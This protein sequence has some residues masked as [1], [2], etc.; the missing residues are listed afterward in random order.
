[1]IL[2]YIVSKDKIKIEN[3]KCIDSL[4]SDNDIPKIIIGREFSKELNVKTSV[5]DKKIDKNS[6]WTYSQKEKKSEYLEDIEK[7]KI[8]C[9]DNFLKKI[10][11]FYI[12]PFSLK[13]SQV[14][15]I[16]KKFKDNKLGLFYFNSD[17]CYIYLDKIIFGIHWETI[18][19][20]GISKN[21]IIEW[22]KSNNFS[23]L[24]KDEIFNKC[25]EDS[26]KLNNAKILPYLYYTR[27]Y[28]KQDFVGDLSR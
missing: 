22:L 13:Y 15:K 14:K 26:Q 7:F 28:D 17:M 16:I 2:G 9:I 4:P 3:F 6:F 19:Y 8:F 12:D 5:L 25:M 24:S 23:I 20:V 27:I 11:Y 10:N 21:K 1:M 18:Q